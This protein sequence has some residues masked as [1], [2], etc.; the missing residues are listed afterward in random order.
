MYLQL[1][2]VSY[3][4]NSE[5]NIIDIGSDQHSLQ[6][7]TN[8]TYCCERIEWRV[9]EWFFPNMSVVRRK[10]DGG[11]FYRDRDQ[12]VVRLHRRHN[13]MMPNGSFCCEIPDANN[14]IQSICI[15]VILPE[16]K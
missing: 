13:V 5:V 12:S 2:G 11:S 15:E 10:G 6:C 4:N 1:N 7:V 9:G 14:E 8:N 16:S 3:G